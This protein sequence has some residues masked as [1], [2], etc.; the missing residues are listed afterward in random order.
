MLINKADG[1]TR[2][3]VDFRKLNEVTVGDC[4]PIPRID[5]SLRAL[6]GAKIFTTV[7]LTKGYWQVPVKESDREKTAFSCHRGLYEFNTMPFGLKGAP[8]TFQRLMTNVLGEFNWKILLIYLDD[9]I[10]YSRSLDEHFEHLNRVFD[11]IRSAGL[12]L[13]PHKCTFARK[14][15]RYLGH[16]VSGDGVAPDPEKIR[17]IREFPQPTNLSELRRF[18]G[19]ASYYRRFIFEFAEIAQLLYIPAEKDTVFR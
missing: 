9:V 6:L 19:M 11:K 13:Q 15:V 2:F 14:Q 16:V 7:D 5:D 12:K 18:L 8:A 4:F 1:S 10:I 17:T 3:C